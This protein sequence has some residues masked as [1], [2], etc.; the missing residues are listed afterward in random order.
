MDVNLLGIIPLAL[1]KDLFCQK[2]PKKNKKFKSKIVKVF[3][4]SCFALIFIVDALIFNTYIGT[5]TP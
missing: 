1:L 5:A 2:T 3:A 4:C